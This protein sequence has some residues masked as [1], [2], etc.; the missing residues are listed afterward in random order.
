MSGVV[1]ATLTLPQEYCVKYF[2]ML[3]SCEKGEPARWLGLHDAF[4][5]F[6]LE[7][8]GRIQEAV[9]VSTAPQTHKEPGGS[10]PKI[11]SVGES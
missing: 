7:A 11:P 9:V 4:L 1:I 3:Y 6:T 10:A 5:L 2:G 8:E